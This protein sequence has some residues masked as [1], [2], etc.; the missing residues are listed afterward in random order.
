[1]PVRCW[2]VTVLSALRLERR[3]GVAVTLVLWLV[4]RRGMA[5]APGNGRAVV[6]MD[7]VALGDGPSAVWPERRRG[8]AVPSRMAVPPAPWPERRRRIAVSS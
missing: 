8:M 1:M 4:R 5:T 3:Q 6:P 2:G 7:G